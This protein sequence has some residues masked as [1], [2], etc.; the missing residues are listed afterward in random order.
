MI[1]TK[2]I[3]AGV[4]VSACNN[5]SQ[6]AQFIS[7]VKDILYF[8]FGLSEENVFQKEKFEPYCDQFYRE[9]DKAKLYVN[10]M[11][12]F[13]FSYY[14]LSEQLGG[15]EWAEIFEALI[16]GEVI[17]PMELY[18]SDEQFRDV[19]NN[20]WSNDDIFDEQGIEFMSEHKP[21]INRARLAFNLLSEGKY[22]KAMENI[23]VLGIVTFFSDQLGIPEKFVC[24]LLERLVSVFFDD[25]N[26]YSTYYTYSSEEVYFYRNYR[27]KLP[28]ELRDKCDKM[29]RVFLN[30]VCV[31]DS[32]TYLI[33]E[34]YYDDRDKRAYNFVTFYNSCD[35]S[36]QYVN[37]DIRLFF[38]QALEFVVG[39][40]LKKIREEYGDA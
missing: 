23:V 16:N 34:T 32:D 9:C 21:Q 40:E 38:P 15:M 28:V 30:P 20:Y 6:A 39:G 5:S 3:D 13:D 25:E 4:H 35:D 37:A 36:S 24:K 7:K 29:I 31:D 12:Y 22:E 27:D 11:T 2:F 14:S 17:S 8:R 19:V 10:E 1:P 26:Y 33:S 18:C